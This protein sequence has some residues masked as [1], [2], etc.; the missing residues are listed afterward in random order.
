MGKG[1]MWTLVHSVSVGL[2]KKRLTLGQYVVEEAREAHV[3]RN[4]AASPR[5]KNKVSL[6]T[7]KAHHPRSG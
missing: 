3:G 2:F 5:A 1:L 4:P 7:F 6:L